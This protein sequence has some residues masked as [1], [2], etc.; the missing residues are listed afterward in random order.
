MLVVEHRRE[1]AVF[2]E[3]LDDPFEELVARILCLAEFVDWIVSMFTDDEDGVDGELVA[4]A[5]KRF[6]DRRV[7]LE[8]ELLCAVAAQIVFGE[9]IDVSRNDIERRA[10][11][12]ARTAGFFS[13]FPK[14]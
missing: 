10:M 4:A 6:R 1:A 13:G 12:L 2:F 9:L 14:T 7:D 11:P 8:S 5:A 3:D